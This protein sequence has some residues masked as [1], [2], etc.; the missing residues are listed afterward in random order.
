MVSNVIEHPKKV[1]KK[2]KNKRKVI[3]QKYDKYITSYK[4]NKTS[5]K[6]IV[7]YDSIIDE[8][9]K[10]VL[11]THKIITHSYMFLKLFVIDHYNKSNDIL[12]IDSKLIMNII[13]TYCKKDNRGRKKDTKNI[14]ILDKLTKFYDKNYKKLMVEKE[15]LSYTNLNNVLE[16]QA[17]NIITCLTNH[18]N[19]HFFDMINRYI[20]IMTNLK[21]DMDKINIRSDINS[22]EKK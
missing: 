15:Q 3:V 18:I 4:C 16:S 5:L 13:K 22:T 6:S 14:D 21:E 2:A 1:R 20:N 12:K 11:I 8:I 9:N 17:V 19:M 7:K 10:V